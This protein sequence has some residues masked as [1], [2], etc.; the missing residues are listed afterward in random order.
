MF[1]ASDGVDV[2]LSRPVPYAPSTAALTDGSERYVR[3]TL[4]LVNHSRSA[5]ARGSVLVKA[6]ARGRQ[7]RAVVDGAK[8]VGR[9]AGWPVRVGETRTAVVAFGLPKGRTVLTVRVDPS[10][11]ADPSADVRFVGAT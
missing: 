5:L 2:T 9:A 1:R 8:G 7:R 11:G 6:W 3:F 10:G 4:T